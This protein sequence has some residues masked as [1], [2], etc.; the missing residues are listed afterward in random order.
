M[1]TERISEKSL[2][3]SKRSDKESKYYKFSYQKTLNIRTEFTSIPNGTS[4]PNLQ[5][6]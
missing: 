1:R 4:K 6:Q 3:I 5:S 2:R